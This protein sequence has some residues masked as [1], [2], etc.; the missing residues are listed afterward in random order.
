MRTTS[1]FIVIHS[2][3][4]AAFSSSRM[5]SLIV[6]Q[7]MAREHRNSRESNPQAVELAVESLETKFPAGLH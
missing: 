1:E 3:R 5:G 6:L 2:M 4:V 7:E